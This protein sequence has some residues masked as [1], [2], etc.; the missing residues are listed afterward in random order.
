MPNPRVPATVAE[1]SSAY[2]IHCSSLTTGRLSDGGYTVELSH[3]ISTASPFSLMPPLGNSTPYWLNVKLAYF[4]VETAGMSPDE[5]TRADLCSPRGFV[6]TRP[7]F[8][9]QS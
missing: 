7:A 3:M 4:E 8:S 2:C 1:P 5:N 9:V 6:T